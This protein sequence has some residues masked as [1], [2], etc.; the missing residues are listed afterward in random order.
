MKWFF[1]PSFRGGLNYAITR[2]ILVGTE[3]FFNGQIAFTETKT[4]SNGVVGSSSSSGVPFNV[5]FKVPTALFL[6]FRY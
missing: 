2:H 4:E 6:V 3:F 1:G 5:G